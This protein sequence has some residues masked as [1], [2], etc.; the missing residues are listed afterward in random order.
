MT[1]SDTAAPQLSLGAAVLGLPAARGYFSP[2]DI[3]PTAWQAQLSQLIWQARRAGA[4]QGPPECLEQVIA[5]TPGS[6]AEAREAERHTLYRPH[7]AGAAAYRGLFSASRG[8]RDWVLQTAPTAVL[9][10]DTFA[11]HQRHLSSPPNPD[12]WPQQLSAVQQALQTRGALPTTLIVV[13]AEDTY[14]AEVCED[15]LTALEGVGSGMTGFALHNLSPPAGKTATE[16]LHRAAAVFPAL[17]SLTLHGA[18]CKLPAASALRGLRELRVAGQAS[19]KAALAFVTQLTSLEITNARRPA[20]PRLFSPITT[21]HTLTHFSTDELLTNEL[22]GLLLEHAP[23]LAQLRVNSVGELSKQ[24]S[25][26]QWKLRSL[27][28]RN[29]V[30]MARLAWLPS[31]THGRVEVVVSGQES[32]VELGQSPQVRLAEMH[33]TVNAPI[34][35]TTPSFLGHLSD[36]H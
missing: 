32:W 30:Y 36:G 25:D 1:E 11:V 10:I 4:E 2:G 17:Q 13:L 19:I 6:A 12:P 20:W 7:A 15:L 28:V 35:C 5:D 23:A 22:L 31:S 33:E 24:H 8:T 14:C 16:V 27:G 26:R 3:A 34:L 18:A 9:C 29:S 21:T